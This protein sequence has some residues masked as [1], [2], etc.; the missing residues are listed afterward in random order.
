MAEFIP[1]GIGGLSARTKATRTGGK[2]GTRTYDR[3]DLRP[4]PRPP[5]GFIPTPEV[6]D[7][8][9]ERALA[10]L[11]RGMIWDRGSIVNLVL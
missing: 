8:L 6:I 5:L 3:Q 11:A 10:A 9:I 7:A 4:P 1:T 2:S